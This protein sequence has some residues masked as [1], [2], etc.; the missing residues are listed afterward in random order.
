MVCARNPAL[1]REAVDLY[2]QG[3]QLR[4]CRQRL[5]QG[6]SKLFPIGMHAAAVQY[7]GGSARRFGSGASVYAGKLVTGGIELEGFTI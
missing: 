6:A 4:V 3:Y 1:C 7:D 2:Q 5:A